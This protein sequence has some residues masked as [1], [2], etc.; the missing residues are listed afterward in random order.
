MQFGNYFGIILYFLIF[1]T[2]AIVSKKKKQTSSDFLIGNRK[3]NF[4]LTALAAHASDMSG[5][6]FIGY[7]AVIF[8][9]G[10]FNVWL[11]IGLV[12]FMFLNWQYVAPRLRRLTEQYNSLTLCSFFESRF[13]DT[14]GVLRILTTLISFFYFS[15]Y[16]S[17]GL[18]GMSL[19]FQ[20]L[21][22]LST[23]VG[24]GIGVLL[25]IPYLFIGG[26]ITL[27]WT[28]LFQGLLLLIVILTIPLYALHFVGGFP[29]IGEAVAKHVEFRH[30]LP[31][32]SWLS[33]MEILFLAC[34]WGL[35][36]F[37]QPHILTKF[38]GIANPS[39][40]P[41][42]KWVGISWQLLALTG[43]TLIGLVGIAFFQNNSLENNQ[44][45]FINLVLSLLPSFLALFI[46]C[47]IVGTCITNID[48]QIL[49]LATNLTEDLYKKVLR[50]TASSKELVLV[51]RLS[52]CLIAGLSYCIAVTSSSSVFGLVEYAWF[53]LG[54][55]FGP[56][57]LFSLYG[58]R[59]NRLGAFAG[60]VS[61]S[62]I[63]AVWPLINKYISIQI[64][65][66]IPGFLISSFTIWFI[67]IITESNSNEQKIGDS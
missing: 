62:F 66:L 14:S 55:S 22:G 56:L 16:I 46:L 18:V 41:K 40:I 53:G 49:V 63:A 8:A 11:A 27:A 50:K 34:G 51:S 54:A 59:T 3:M 21:F 36:Y 67:S 13:G 64:P 7:P 17:G 35:G 38:M 43:S 19:L 48:S 57:I 23:P 28:D 26:Y 10:L 6:I 37:G 44:L 31:T 24:M 2:I 1:L 9:T 61:G 52:V 45:V 32:N 12:L 25:V 47:A 4:F 60:L 42:A 65:T 20:T 29:G 33:W 5:W 15:I 58:K 39:E 30:W